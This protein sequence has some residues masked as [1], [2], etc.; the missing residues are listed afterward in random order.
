MTS[1]FPPQQILDLTF[2]LYLVLVQ[3]FMPPFSIKEIGIVEIQNTTSTVHYIQY[4]LNCALQYEPYDLILIFYVHYF[5]F[6]MFSNCN[7]VFFPIHQ[8]CVSNISN[9]VWSPVFIWHFLKLFWCFFKVPF[10][11]FMLMMVQI[12]HYL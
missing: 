1:F 4:T 8:S 6:K 10:Q 9:D 11:L 7:Y 2:N 5:N 3:S 12:T